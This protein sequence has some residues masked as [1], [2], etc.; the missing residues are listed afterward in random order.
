MVTEC[1]SENDTVIFEN[2]LFIKLLSQHKKMMGMFPHLATLDVT[3]KSWGVMGKIDNQAQMLS[4]YA[5]NFK[6]QHPGCTGEKELTIHHL[7]HKNIKNYVEL[8]RYL[9][10]RHYWNNQIILCR[11]H[12]DEI[13]NFTTG[14]KQEGAHISNKK[15]EK[16]KKQFAEYE[17]K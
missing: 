15:I 14:K 3:D 4:L 2:A 5:A 11:D 17:K 10:M 16:I 1:K 12:H 13:D 6:C 7:V 8:H 9:S